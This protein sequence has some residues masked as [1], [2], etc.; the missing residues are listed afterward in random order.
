MT[1]PETVYADLHTHSCCSDGTLAPEAL[2]K[3][4]AKRGVRVL[5]VT[6]HD[7]IDGFG[8]AREAARRCG[9]RLVPGVELSVEVQGR[10]IHLLG[11][12]FDP[13]HSAINDYLSM[14]THRRR[15]RFNRM[16]QRLSNAGV[17]IVSRILDHRVEGSSAPGRPHLARA[18]V[19]SGHVDSYRAA[20]DV[21]LGVDRPAY[22]PAPTRPASEAIKVLHTAGG[23]G[24]LAHPGHWMPSASI[25][26]L[27]EA[28]LDGIETIHPSHDASLQQYYERQARGYT[29]VET[30][31]SDYHGR[32]VEED[33]HL[34]TVGLTRTQWERFREALA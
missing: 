27:V 13:G 14:F 26:Q 32:V 34:G 15:E 16:V 25:R 28:G 24:V 1:S 8:E 18:L 10:S 17:E 33:E 3:R 2:V 12:D 20:F 19:D 5:A 22:V 7:T 23:V 11:Y 31:G 30:G 9:I 29:L 4:A 6:D 21:Y